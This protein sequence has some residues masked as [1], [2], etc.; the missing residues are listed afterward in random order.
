MRD[1]ETVR[2]SFFYE[3]RARRSEPEADLT[4]HE[5]VDLMPLSIS[6][7]ALGECLRTGDSA[8]LEDRS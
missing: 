1:L 8:V 3:V 6:H 5:E 2:A 4:A 7:C